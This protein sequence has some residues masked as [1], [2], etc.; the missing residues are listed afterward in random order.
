[1]SAATAIDPISVADLRAGAYQREAA[2]PDDLAAFPDSFVRIATSNPLARDQDP[3]GFVLRQHGVAV[4]RVRLL[5]GEVRIGEQVAPVFW[6]MDLFSSPEHRAGGVGALLVKRMLRVLTASGACVGSFASTREAL[7][8]YEVLKMRTVGIVPRYLWPLR[9]RPILRA[10]M[11]DGPA[12]I[13][14]PLVDAI[15]RGVEPLVHAPS[16]WRAHAFHF[17][18][19]DTFDPEVDELLDRAARAGRCGFPART[20]ILNWRMAS[21][22]W[23]DPRKV[24]RAR[25]IYG[26]SGQLVGATITRA[27]RHERIAGHPYRDLRVLSLMDF[28]IDDRTPGAND[29]VLA[30]LVEEGRRQEV[31][32]I[33]VMTNDREMTRALKTARFRRVGGSSFSFYSGPD[34][35]AP[36]QLDDWRLTMSAGDGFT[37]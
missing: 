14:A 18:Y 5:R 4:S 37:S 10:R 19:R 9:S 26:A 7:A 13:A 12:R 32:V 17:E 33:E 6:D 22:R 21:M 2:S 8:V 34:E 3:V 31:D 27:R 1:M 29:A 36:V 23:S 25:T 16:R 20:E 35:R 24:V 15:A 11:G 28:W 30:D